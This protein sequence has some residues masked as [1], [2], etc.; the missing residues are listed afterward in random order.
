M[1]KREKWEKRSSIL[2]YM[3]LGG[4]YAM[5]LPTLFSRAKPAEP[6]TT[7]L[8]R[9]YEINEQLNSLEI[10]RHNYIDDYVSFTRTDSTME[11]IFFRQGALISERDSLE[12]LTTSD[13][14]KKYFTDLIR[15]LKHRH[16]RHLR[17]TF[18]GYLVPVLFGV[19]AIYCLRKKEN[20]DETVNSEETED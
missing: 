3:L 13:Q 20:M 1:D 18:S 17:Q 6:L 2:G 7:D 5:S 12:S 4:I 10:P 15:E 14:E 8:H 19:A 9:V 11:T 16:R